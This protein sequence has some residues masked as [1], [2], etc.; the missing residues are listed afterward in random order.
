MSHRSLNN[1]E[2]LVGTVYVPSGET[3]EIPYEPSA[4]DTQFMKL[5][6]EESKDAISEGNVAVGAVMSYLDPKTNRLKH[7]SAHSTE[8]I[9]NNLVAHAEDNV[10]NEI[11]PILGRDLTSATLYVTTEPCNSCAHSYVIQ[12]HIGALFIA[13]SRDDTPHYF[14][15]K[16][17]TLDKQLRD[18]G[19]TILVVRGLM[20]EEALKNLTAATKVHRSG[21]LST[22]RK[23]G[24]SQARGISPPGAKNSQPKR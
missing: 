17:W 15:Q 8:V 16:E 6:V 7:A 14:R 1:P 19:R 4:V 13:T 9:S 11:Q 24:R 23:T 10:Y 22:T 20:R 18:A 21:P 12:G 5:A 2:T 3:Y